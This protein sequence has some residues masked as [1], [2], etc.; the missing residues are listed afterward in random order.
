MEKYHV[1][2]IVMFLA[3]YTFAFTA[4]AYAAMYYFKAPLLYVHDEQFRIAV[5]A[6]VIAILGNFIMY[7]AVSDYFFS[8]EAFYDAI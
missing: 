4:L 8:F 1:I 5:A 6:S 2:I 3:R 7:T